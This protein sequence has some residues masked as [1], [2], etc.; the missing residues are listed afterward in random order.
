MFIIFDD[1][2]QSVLIRVV[3]I[4]DGRLVVLFVIVDFD[5]WVF[6]DEFCLMDI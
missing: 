1:G 4:L 5:V 3:F 2:L 6:E